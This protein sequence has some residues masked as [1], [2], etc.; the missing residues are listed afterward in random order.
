MRFMQSEFNKA[1]VPSSIQDITSTLQL[2]LCAAMTHIEAV[3]GRTY[4]FRVKNSYKQK[5]GETFWTSQF[6]PNFTDCILHAF[7][8]ALNCTP[9]T[10]LTCSQY[11]T[12]IQSR[13]F[14][15]SI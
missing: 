9:M 3:R 13:K 5:Y 10:I 1:K 4:V 15:H 7:S 8:N 12:S 2:R 14:N 6:I 11:I